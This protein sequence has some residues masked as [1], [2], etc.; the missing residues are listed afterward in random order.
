[1][2]TRLLGFIMLVLSSCIFVGCE[3]ETSW[4][5]TTD[6]SPIIAEKIVDPANWDAEITSASLDQLVKVIG[7]NL[8]N[9][10]SV[11]VNDIEAAT[12]DNYLVVNGELFLRI[13]Y[14]VPSVVDN[15]LKITDKF[16]N[17]VELE[18]TVT[19]PDLIV[20]GMSCEYAP[21]GTDLTISG[22]YLD[23]YEY[24]TVNG[25]VTFGDIEVAIKQADKTSVIVTVPEDVPENTVVSL[26]SSV[27]T[28]VC[29]GKYKDTECLISN[30]ESNV[31][32]STV[33]YISGPNDET[34]DCGALSTDP[35]GISGKYLRYKNTY[36]AWTWT[37][38]SW[39]AVT[40]PSDLAENASEYYIKF[41]CYAVNELNTAFL[42][43]APFSGY[44]SYRWGDDTSFPLGEWR[45][46][47]IPISSTVDDISSW[48]NA[49]Q[50]QY[51][52]HGPASEGEMYFAIDNIRISR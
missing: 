32:G 31:T 12:P 42:L 47:S 49:T 38:F 24:D 6:D 18:L 52:L 43:I 11:F 15:K 37:G 3:E 51:V 1:M 23:L 44:N 35:E 46:Y 34:P 2:K 10:Q 28:T 30:F 17:T 4:L 33:A 14:T 25:T 48:A 29:P 41:E 39:P 20:E 9:T 36:S 27:Q 19:I 26:V 8:G 45:T 50:L 40:P 13:P 22:D 21:A 16:D 5:V 7:T